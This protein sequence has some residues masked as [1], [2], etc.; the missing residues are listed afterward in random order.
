[1][2]G[3]FRSLL[4]TSHY[5]TWYA[6]PVMRTLLLF[7]LSGLLTTTGAFAMGS[8]IS[9]DSYKAGRSSSV[10]GRKSSRA[11]ER[12][13]RKSTHSKAYR[14][15][16]ANGTKRHRYSAKG[17]IHAHTVKGGTKTAKT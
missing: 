10:P 6:C 5:T 15:T 2:A 16:R 12:V 1:M 8:K 4:H 14:H 9:S 17:N 3:T 7:V 11:R 13:T